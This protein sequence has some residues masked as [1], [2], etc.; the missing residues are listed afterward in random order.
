V[1]RA[2]LV[3][4]CP[5]PDYA[6]LPP[7][8][9]PERDGLGLCKLQMLRVASPEAR[10]YGPALLTGLSLLRYPAFTSVPAAARVRARLES[11]RPELVAA[12]VHLI[13]TQLPD[14]DLIIGDSHE[15][16]ANASPFGV[17]AIDRLILAEARAL[18]GARELEVRQRWHGVYPSAPGD[19]FLVTAPLPGVRVVEVVSG[20][21]MTTALGLAIRVVS[22]LLGDLSEQ[23]GAEAGQP[24]SL[25]RSAGARAGY[26]S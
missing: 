17:E 23:R 5:G 21:G 1:V 6:T 20:V 18:L 22:E 2:P 19:P 13:V 15:Y 10:R 9:R 7:Q 26:G 14:G 12:G 16:G 8:V 3:I 4:V 11:E 24:A 25:P